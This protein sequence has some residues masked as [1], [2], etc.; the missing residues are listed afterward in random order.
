[1][2]PSA[3]A[4]DSL[5]CSQQFGTA[6]SESFYWWYGV[7]CSETTRT[8]SFHTQPE[9]V[10]LL[11]QW[12]SMLMCLI[13]V[14][15]ES[16]YDLRVL[17]LKWRKVKD[18]FSHLTIPQH[19][20]CSSA[21]LTSRSVWQEHLVPFPCIGILSLPPSHLQFLQ[22]WPNRGEMSP[23]AFLNISHILGLLGWGLRVFCVI[24]VFQALH[25]ILIS[26]V[27]SAG[28]SEAGVLSPFHAL[29]FTFCLTLFPFKSLFPWSVGV[30]AFLWEI[31]PL[32]KRKK[33]V[34]CV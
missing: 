17:L 2:N 15:G 3:R 30:G 4:D 20:Q 7:T 12:R 33:K 14:L 32:T 34:Y 26:I 28:V 21:D 24:T 31:S 10:E 16:V 19:S 22:L 9:Q 18:S 1:M 27:S 23:H 25:H 11:L 5:V 29:F 8:K 6:N 13:M